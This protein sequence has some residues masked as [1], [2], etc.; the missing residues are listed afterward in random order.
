LGLK[1]MGVDGALRAACAWFYKNGYVS[2]AGI[3]CSSCSVG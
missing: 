3:S 1:V 2:K